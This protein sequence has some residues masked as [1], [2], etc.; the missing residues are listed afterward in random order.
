MRRT[1]E[2]QENS[3]QGV[4]PTGGTYDHDKLIQLLKS[5]FP[6]LTAELDDEITDGLLHPQMGA[7]ARFTQA[8]IDRRDEALTKKCF[9]VASNVFS[10]CTPDVENAL[11]VSYLEHI[12]LTDGRRQRSWALEA[13]PPT[14]RQGWHDMNQYLEDLFRRG[15]QSK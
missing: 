14:L 9:D 2:D 4:T 12:Y 8:A 11:N 6:A 15:G 3:P 13:M 1:R 10:N 7:F 5:Q